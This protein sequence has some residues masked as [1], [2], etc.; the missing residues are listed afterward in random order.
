VRFLKLCCRAAWPASGRFCRGK[1]L[2]IFRK[3]RGI[4]SYYK[5]EKG[6]AKRFSVSILAIPTLIAQEEIANEVNPLCLLGKS[7]YH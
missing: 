2:R 5:Q 6:R 1:V 7:A 3:F 4:I